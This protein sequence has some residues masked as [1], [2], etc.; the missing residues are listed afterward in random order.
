MKY[1]TIEFQRGFE[2][3]DLVRGAPAHGRGVAIRWSSGVPSNLNHSMI[4]LYETM[5]PCVEG[6]VIINTTDNINNKESI[7]NYSMCNYFQIVN[8]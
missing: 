1:F 6:Q 5:S 7:L 4:L 8:F 2:Q 3:P